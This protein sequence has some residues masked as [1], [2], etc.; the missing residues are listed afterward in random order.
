MQ[1][2]VGFILLLELIINS[3]LFGHPVY[4]F[5]FLFIVNQDKDKFGRKKNTS[6][7]TPGGS[8]MFCKGLTC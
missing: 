2:F 3:H 4:Y 6:K 1:L 8:E 7:G 5:V